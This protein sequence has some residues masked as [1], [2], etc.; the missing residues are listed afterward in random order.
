ADAINVGDAQNWT[1]QSS[2]CGPE[3]PLKVK[4]NTTAQPPQN[5]HPEM[6]VQIIC[7][8]NENPE[9]IAFY[10]QLS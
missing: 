1:L 4:P 5:G 3:M 8:S 6:S 2:A 7:S 10:F 9:F